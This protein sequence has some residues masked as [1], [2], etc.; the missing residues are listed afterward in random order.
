[1]KK[2]YIIPNIKTIS[3]KTKNHMLFGSELGEGKYN[4]G[5]NR[6]DYG[7][8]QASRQSSSWDDED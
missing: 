5:G 4:G 7:G 2:Q 8:G 3:V 6:G 1:M